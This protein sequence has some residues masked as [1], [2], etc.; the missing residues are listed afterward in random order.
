MSNWLTGFLLT[1]ALL[2]AQMDLDC[3]SPGQARAWI[4]RLMLSEIEGAED[5]NRATM[6]EAFG[7]CP[8]GPK[9]GTCREDARRSFEAQWDERKRAIQDKYRKMLADFE[10]R[11]RASI[12]HLAPAGHGGRP[13]G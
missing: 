9:A 2:G 13:A 6:W 12:T 10:E 4:G 8:P 7:R 5:E 3:S 11:C 1:G